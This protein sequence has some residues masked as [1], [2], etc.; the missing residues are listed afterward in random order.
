MA[1]ISS[2]ETIQY[3]FKY[4]LVVLYGLAKNYLA[5]LAY[6]APSQRVYFPC[7]V[8][9]LYAK[10]RVN[11]LPIKILLCQTSPHADQLIRVLL[12]CIKQ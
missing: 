8:L 11:V 4:M 3:I 10:E 1:A 12:K 9:Q 7:Y 2:L 5:I 6:T